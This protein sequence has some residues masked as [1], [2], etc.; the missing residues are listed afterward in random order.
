MSL[1]SGS[2]ERGAVAQRRAQR[3]LNVKVGDRPVQ[4]SRSQRLT[5][6]PRTPDSRKRA[7]AEM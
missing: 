7:Q 1:S 5:W 3:V 4:R 2:S 6:H